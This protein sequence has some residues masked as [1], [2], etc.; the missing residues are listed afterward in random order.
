MTAKPRPLSGLPPA[1]ITLGVVSLLTDLSSEMIYPLLPIFLTTV[2]G[3]GPI[4]IGLIKGLAESSL[5]FGILWKTLGPPV[6]FTVGAGLAAIAAAILLS[7][8]EG[9][10]PP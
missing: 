4:A 1:V 2:L 3:A 8:P 10:P 7:M 9:E 5:I 6:A